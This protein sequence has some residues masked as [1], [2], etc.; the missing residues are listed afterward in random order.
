[1]NKEKFGFRIFLSDGHVVKQSIDVQSPKELFERWYKNV[2]HRFYT[3]LQLIYM[4]EGEIPREY[5]TLM[6]QMN[7]WSRSLGG[8]EDYTAWWDTMKH[9]HVLIDGK[10]YIDRFYKYQIG[11]RGISHMLGRRFAPS[12]VIRGWSHDVDGEWLEYIE[13]NKSNWFLFMDSDTSTDIYFQHRRD[14]QELKY[15]LEFSGRQDNHFVFTVPE[16]SQVNR[17]LLH[18]LGGII[19]VMTFKPGIILAKH[20]TITDETLMPDDEEDT[21]MNIYQGMLARI[22]KGKCK[23]NYYMYPTVDEMDWHRFNTEIIEQQRK[24]MVK[25]MYEK[26]ERIDEIIEEDE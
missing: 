10:D 23:V 26:V 11:I 7:N 15:M 6:T 1:M 18:Y 25:K 21:S 9:G 8:S 13:D 19:E 20:I 3:N 16:S 4:G 12:D 2:N 22:R 5:D 17:M 14:T 24:D